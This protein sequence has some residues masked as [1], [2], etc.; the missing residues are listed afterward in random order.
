MLVLVLTSALFD[1]FFGL[2]WFDGCKVFLFLFF[3][4]ESLIEGFVI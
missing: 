2:V 1:V 3:L 4:W